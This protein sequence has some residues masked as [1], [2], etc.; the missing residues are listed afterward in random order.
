MRRNGWRGGLAAAVAVTAL[1]CG[2]AAL[3]RALTVED[4]LEREAFGR[5]VL[6]ERW[7]LA[8]V[9]GP[10]ARAA[11]F[12][13]DTR[14]DLLRTTLQAAPTTAPEGLHPLL[15]A[16]PGVGYALGP[17]GPHGDRV[18]V[19]RLKAGRWELGVA[20]P[21]TGAVRWLG[22]TP[23]LTATGR[24]VAWL[25]PATLLV[26]ALPD[27]E[28]PL[29]LKLRR[30]PRLVAERQALTAAGGASP[31]VIGS[32]RYL[33]LRPQAAARRLLRIDLDVPATAVLTEG[34]FTD[35]E[36]SPDGRRVALLAEGGDI[37][38]EA[39]R[40]VQ[41]DRGIETQRSRLRLLD[42][43]SGRLQD[44]CRD[45]DVLGQLLRWS[46]TADELLVFA[47]RDGEAWTQGRLL[48]V[49]AT[50][51]VAQ[52]VGADVR[53]V[54][55]GRPAVVRASWLGRDPIVF[56]RPIGDVGAG[57]ADWFRLAGERASRLTAALLDASGET[58]ILWQET[59]WLASGGRL[60]R[61]DRH[62]ATA[63]TPPDEK[64]T[65]L[66]TPPADGLRPRSDLS[67]RAG[68]VAYLAG[69]GGLALV[70]L[71]PGRAGLSLPPG[72]E[73]LAADPAG[74]L[75]RT[76]ADTG[77]ER[78]AWIRAGA[79]PSTLGAIN[80]H[81]TDVDDGRVLPVIHTGPRGET[82]TSWLM[83]P[84]PAP[85][86]PRPPLVVWPYPGSSYPRFPAYFGAKQGG[87]VE[88]PALLAAHGFA[89]LVP[90]LPSP[91]GGAGPAD[92]L[93][94]RVLAIVGRAASDPSTRGTFD[95]SRL[96]IWGA[97]FGGYGTLA[98]LTQTDRFK[99]AIVQ[100]APT[101]LVSMHGDF[102]LKRLVLPEGGLGSTP[103]AGWTEDLQGDMRAPP[104]ADPARYVRNSP[105]FAA[106]RIRTPLLIFHGDQD[107][108]PIGQA[109]EMFSS[110]H[111]QDKDVVLVTYWG[112][113]HA[114]TSPGTIRDYYARA[115]AWLNAHLKPSSSADH[116]AT[117]SP[118]PAPGPAS[119]APSPPPWP[120]P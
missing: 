37:A 58:A 93:A 87:G 54:V 41:G 73:V 31:T 35:F 27:G 8:E 103:S 10:Y 110:L 102:G 17:A 59:L 30:Y 82:L 19:F 107:T 29:D 86:A 50:D 2:P 52:A 38:P 112:E 60:W 4:V 91:G 96:G 81:L 101:D 42:L 76:P 117:R 74:A 16:E 90:S 33:R 94:D 97:S 46:P 116:P 72:A 66:V 26:L 67:P 48:R 89:V 22:V 120:R 43:A 3:P 55:S 105:I 69:R 65:G 1:A 56:A 28:E 47:R 71:A 6:T 80:A 9:R 111:R 57:R 40:P 53:P 77:P 75:V 34:P 49:R 14:T 7:I 15:P 12:D 21:A 84:P 64:V 63:V 44:A 5:V 62:G 99:A 79:Q 88:A 109:E 106:D 95:A 36:P 118:G 61:L 32:G 23:N 20:R 104:W 45:C 13:Y 11:R 51:G 114:F 113:G 98:I 85:D 68:P 24:A 78:L 100:G 70:H 83:L 39:S 108:I 92:G 25:G 18:A 115:F 119:S